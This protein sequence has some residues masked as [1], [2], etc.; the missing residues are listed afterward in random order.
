MYY[1]DT[2]WSDERKLNKFIDAVLIKYK[3]EFDKKRYIL[4][5]SLKF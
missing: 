1:S 4:M 3:H 5:V 2:H